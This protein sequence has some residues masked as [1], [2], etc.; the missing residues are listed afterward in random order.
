[1]IDRYAGYKKCWCAFHARLATL[2]RNGT[3]CTGYKMIDRYTSWWEDRMVYRQI[4]LYNCL[5]S[6]G[7]IEP[8]LTTLHAVY[9]PCCVLN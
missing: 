2:S 5:T 4:V 6:T 8:V 7:A 9:T 1:M 3:T